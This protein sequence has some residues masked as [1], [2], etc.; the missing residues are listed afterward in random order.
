MSCDVWT[1]E[2]VEHL[3]DTAGWIIAGVIVV[4]FFARSSF[5]INFREKE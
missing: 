1:P 4:W 2:A 3:I 5:E